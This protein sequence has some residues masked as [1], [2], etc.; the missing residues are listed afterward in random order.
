MSARM[1]PLGFALVLLAAFAQ[2]AFGESPFAFD[3]TPG[4]LPKTVVPRHYTIRLEPNLERF[5]TQGTVTVDLDVL[6]PV[7]EIVLNALDS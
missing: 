6:R 2:L 7:S 3:S 5:T 1:R 4:K